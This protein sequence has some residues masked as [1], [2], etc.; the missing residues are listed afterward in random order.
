MLYGKINTI[1]K[2]LARLSKK[3]KRRHKRTELGTKNGNIITYAAEINKIIRRFINLETDKMVEFLEEYSY[4][5]T[6]SRLKGKFMTP[7]AQLT[8]EK[9]RHIGP[10][11]N[12]K[13]FVPEKNFACSGAYRELL[14]LN[15]KKPKNLIKIGL[16]T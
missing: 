1:E 3:K 13:T 10:H 12:E 16:K 6:D 11:E 4:I 15:N 8:K 5:Q 14:K 7:K 9:N 2:P